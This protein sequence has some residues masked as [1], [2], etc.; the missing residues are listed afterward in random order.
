M[1][2]VGRWVGS[3]GEGN[4]CKGDEAVAGQGREGQ[5]EEGQ[6]FFFCIRSVPLLPTP[7]LL[8]DSCPIAVLSL[9]TSGVALLFQPNDKRAKLSLNLK[10]H[11]SRLPPVIC[12]RISLFPLRAKTVVSVPRLHSFSF[13]LN[14]VKSAFHPHSPGNQLFQGQE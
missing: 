3:A 12:C 11:L 1:R 4:G 5:A 6:P 7:Y 9:D 13:P 10:K 8:K 14:P 2:S